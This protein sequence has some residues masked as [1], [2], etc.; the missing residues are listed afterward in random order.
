MCP[1]FLIFLHG[2]KGET[3]PAAVPLALA[4]T[5][6]ATF[7]TVNRATEIRLLA[8]RQMGAVLKEMP[9]QDG[10]PV[11]AGDKEAP[12]T[13]ADVGITRIQSSDAQ[14]LADIPEPEFRE[15][16]AV[17]TLAQAPRSRA[18]AYRACHRGGGRNVGQRN[19]VA[20][21]RRWTI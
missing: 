20:E 10:K 17:A 16:I 4:F 13:L 11:L 7:P 14:K 8:E 6:L 18:R 5:S 3:A 12:P 9:M 1:Q 21:T 15:R 19:G 2:R